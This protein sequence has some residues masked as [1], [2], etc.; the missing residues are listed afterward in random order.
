MLQKI[1]I[2]KQIHKKGRG[3]YHRGKLR[4]KKADVLKGTI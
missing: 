2:S 1:K 3:R 4:Q